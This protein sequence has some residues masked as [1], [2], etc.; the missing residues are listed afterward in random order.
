[1]VPPKSRVTHRVPLEHHKAKLLRA[2][3]ELTHTNETIPP[4]TAKE[5]KVMMDKDYFKLTWN[6]GDPVPGTTE[7]ARMVGLMDHRWRLPRGNDP[8]DL[9]KMNEWTGLWERVLTQDTPVSWENRKQ[10]MTQVS[11]LWPETLFALNCDGDKWETPWIEYYQNGMTQEALG[12]MIYP[13]FDPSALVAGPSGPNSLQRSFTYRGFLVYGFPE[14]TRAIPLTQD[15]EEALSTQTTRKSLFVETHEKTEMC[16][17]IDQIREHPAEITL[18][19]KQ[20]AREA[21]TQAGVAIER[22]AKA[23]RSSDPTFTL[24]DQELDAT[25]GARVVISEQ[26]VELAREMQKGER[27]SQSP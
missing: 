18:D 10:V 13:A 19:P 25:P 15:A 16:A 27:V 20:L 11:R 22:A 24:L 2:L 9:S 7:I 3:E 17:A 6:G 5:R 21:R 12:A 1:M 23:F 8:P 14:G 4:K 26:M